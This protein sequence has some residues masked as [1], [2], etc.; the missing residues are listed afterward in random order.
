MLFGLFT[1]RHQ[2]LRSLHE[3]SITAHFELDYPL[4]TSSESPE[5]QQPTCRKTR[6]RPGVAVAISQTSSVYGFTIMGECN[7]NKALGNP[8]NKPEQGPTVYGGM[9]ADK[10]F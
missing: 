9:W 2:H 1:S 5:K 4:I 10:G 8:A 6:R 3:I 7:L